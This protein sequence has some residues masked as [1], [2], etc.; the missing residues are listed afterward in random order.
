MTYILFVENCHCY[1]LT[2]SFLQIAET[3]LWC[4]KISWTQD[5]RVQLKCPQSPSPTR[6]SSGNWKSGRSTVSS[7]T[8]SSSVLMCFPRMF[9]LSSGPGCPC[10][11]GSWG[12]WQSGRQWDGVEGCCNIYYHGT[13]SSS[14]FC[15]WVERAK[16]GQMLCVCLLGWG[17]ARCFH[18]TYRRVL[19]GHECSWGDQS[20]VLG[21]RSFHTSCRGKWA[22]TWSLSWWAKSW[23]GNAS[24][25]R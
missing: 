10:A 22:S 8:S 24:F 5:L 3:V 17:T 4:E 11:A 19:R 9:H 1:I 20:Q 15:H 7:L 16:H 13:I 21:R 18:T 12:Q 6:H 2:H 25:F 14:T 23:T